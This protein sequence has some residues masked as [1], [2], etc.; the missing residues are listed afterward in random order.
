MDFD[1]NEYNFIERKKLQSRNTLFWVVSLDKMGSV[2]I[3]RNFFFFVD[4]AP[5]LD[6]FGLDH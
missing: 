6:V 2:F 5:Y 1:E 4:I 3:K